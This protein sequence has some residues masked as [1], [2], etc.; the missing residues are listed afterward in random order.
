MSLPNA[1]GCPSTIPERNK[2]GPGRSRTLSC[3]VG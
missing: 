1:E 3:N 2:K